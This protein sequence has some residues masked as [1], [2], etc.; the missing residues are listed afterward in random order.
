M[1]KLTILILLSSG[2]AG[3]STLESEA[4]PQ[5]KS[6]LVG[7]LLAIFPGFVVHGLG[8]RYA[9]NIERAN[10]LLLME[11]YS[12]LVAALGGGL[13]ALGRSEDAEAVE[14]AGYV[15]MGIAAVPFFGSWI[16]DIVYT[17]SEVEKHNRRLEA[18][19]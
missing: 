10:E 2:C 13:V 11:G 6:V 19:R 1:R 12:L 14:I 4:A 7:Q 18:P 5:E 15:A 3:R 16:Y 17:A 8:H 9:G